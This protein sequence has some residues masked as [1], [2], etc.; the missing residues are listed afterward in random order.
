MRMIFD[1]FFDRLLRRTAAIR[2]QERWVPYAVDADGVYRSIPGYTPTT[3][4]TIR[5]VRVG[6]PVEIEALPHQGFGT[7]TFSIEPVEEPWVIEGGRTA[8]G[9]FPRERLL[10]R[11]FDDVIVRPEGRGWAWMLTFGAGL[12][13]SAVARVTVERRRRRRS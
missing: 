9:F 3:E 10:A 4:T 13:G 7:L 1:C 5:H 2:V 12:D 8:I 11:L 6:V